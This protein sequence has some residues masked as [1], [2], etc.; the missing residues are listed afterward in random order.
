[1]AALSILHLDDPQIGVVA[2]LTLDIGV[3]RRFG[4]RFGPRCAGP[5][6]SFVAADLDQNREG[7]VEAVD[8]Q[9]DGAAGPVA[10]ADHGHRHGLRVGGPDMGHHPEI[11]RKPFIHGDPVFSSTGAVGH[12]PPAPRR[13]RRE[14]MG[15]HV[16]DLGT[17]V[18]HHA[19]G[20]LREAAA[21]YRRVL[22]DEPGEPR[23]LHM[24]AVTAA[25]SGDLETARRG[26]LRS[27]RIAFDAPAAA[28]LGGA[29]H[30]LG[31]SADAGAVLRA[32]LALDPA[33]PDATDTL[34][35][36]LHKGGDAAA[37]FV[38][39]LR[40][41]RLAP[42]RAEPL[43]NLGTVLRDARHFDA[44]DSAFAAALERQPG[45]SAA[46]LG[47]AVGRLVR[48]DFVRGFAGFEHRWKRFA[49]PPWSGEPVEGRTVLLH[50]EQGFGDTIQFA[51]YAPMVADRGARVLVRAHPLLTRLLG[52]L[53]PRLTIQAND[54]PMP[55]HD[56]HCPLM[57]LPRAFGTV[58][59][60]IPARSAYLGADPALVERWAPRFAGAAGPRIGLVW[61]G[62]P[63]HANDHN[64]SLPPG[65]L[66]PLFAARGARFFSLQT[67]D[68]RADLARLPADGVVDLID[69]VTDFADTAAILMHLDL[70][71]AVDTA[72]VHLAG[73]LGR[74][75][76]LLLPYAPDWRWLLD[77][78]DSPWYAS[79]RLFRQP[80]PCDWETTVATVAACLRALCAR[81][82]RAAAR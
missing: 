62:N 58:P 33:Q 75:C 25:Q 63:R 36:V 66:A 9:K 15:S 7:P 53:D 49:E 31:R 55:A 24:L 13:C 71:I 5:R 68:A 41:H 74:P 51:R 45:L 2:K 27:L 76:W 30:G 50:A 11:R 79:L 4:N 56:R 82:E 78:A 65:R 40:A 26:L 52:T 8:L 64:R 18:N 77:R 22:A 67:G 28:N 69:G 46:H 39:L 3:G 6:Q 19:A 60:T 44:A 47:R 12:S 21:L 70:L 57:S 10:T 1:M 48:G 43:L 29:L 20:R 72:I 38:W 54:G 61:A 23:A 16:D 34:G 81:Q 14:G 73:A 37:A 59:E 80:R 42:G 32:A 35:A 17:A